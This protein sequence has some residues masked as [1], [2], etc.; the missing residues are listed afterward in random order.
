MKKWIALF[1]FALL[2][3][4]PVAAQSLHQVAPVGYWS[5]TQPGYDGSNGTPLQITVIAR[6]LPDHTFYAVQKTNDGGP[7]VGSSSPWQGVWDTVSVMDQQ[8]VCVRRTS[9][10]GNVCVY[11]VRND[12]LFYVDTPLVPHTEQEVATIAPELVTGPPSK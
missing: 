9:V 11:S 5:I 8:M 2:G 1:L 10:R 3:A 7:E 4:A 12:S 6:F